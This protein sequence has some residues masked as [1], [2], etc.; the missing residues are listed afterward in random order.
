MF[1]SAWRIHAAHRR[2]FLALGAVFVPLG[3]LAAGIQAL[4]LDHTPF[5]DPRGIEG[6]DR[7]ISGVAALLVGSGMTAL[8]PGVLVAAAVAMSVDELARGHSGG[9]DVRALGARLLPLAGAT[10]AIVIVVAL[11]SSTIVGLIAAVVFLVWHANTTQACVIERRPAR[12]ALRRSRELVHH[13]AWR[14]FAITAVA[15]GIGLATGPVV[16]LAVL[17][18]SSASLGAIDI[19]SSVVYAV[20]M[21]YVSIVLVLLFFDLRAQA[22]SRA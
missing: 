3:V 6:G 14:V 1:V 17:F 21:P 13:Q 20:V 8:V 2:R 12:A 22:G 19:V 10:L 15:T 4:V 5:T 9:I 11:L 18:A 16:G 7:F